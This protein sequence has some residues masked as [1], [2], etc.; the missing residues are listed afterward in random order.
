MDIVSHALSGAVVGYCGLR[1]HPQGGRLALW[2]AIAAAEFPDLDIFMLAWGDEAYLRWHR[3]VTHSV[4]CWPVLAVLVAGI[5]WAF[6]RR[7]PFRVLYGAALAGIGV[8]LLLDWIT[9]YGTELLWPLTDRRFELGWVFILDPYVWALFGV[10]LW[11]AIRTQQPRAAAIG[12]AVFVGYVLMCGAFATATRWRAAATPHLQLATYP[13]PLNP[14]RHTVV[15]TD[16]NGTHWIAGRLNDSFVSYRD[17]VLTPQA[18]ATGVV[19]LYRWF[20]AFPVVERIEHDEF[21]LL[22]Y[23]DLRFR[24]PLPWGGVREGMFVVAKVYFDRQGRL[25]AARLASD[26]R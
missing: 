24:S 26:E 10:T 16:A 13:Q 12:L 19:K 20:A 4:F 14:F 7:S 17:E 9:T 18:E 21:I 11:A 8:H 5:F 25:L 23:R 2:T 22:R 3:S 1:Q 15:R 6:S